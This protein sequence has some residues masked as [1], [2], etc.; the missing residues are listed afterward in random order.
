MKVV[1]EG[2]KFIKYW[3]WLS[4]PKNGINN[5]CVDPKDPFCFI[6]WKNSTIVSGFVASPFIS[7]ATKSKLISLNLFPFL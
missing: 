7:Y 6:S 5:A 4:C 2:L 3:Q 1:P